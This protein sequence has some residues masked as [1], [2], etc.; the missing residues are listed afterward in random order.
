MAD[1]DEA[2]VDPCGDVA[3]QEEIHR[4]LDHRPTRRS[5]GLSPVASLTG[6]RSATACLSPTRRPKP[7]LSCRSRAPSTW[8]AAMSAALRNH[9]YLAAQHGRRSWQRKDRRTVI[10]TAGS[11][12]GRSL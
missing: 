6:A 11:R 1:V 8:T 10:G 3:E 5:E 4:D 7:P 2:T 9:G 12:P